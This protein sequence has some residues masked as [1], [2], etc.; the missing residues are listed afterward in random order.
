MT[1]CVFL[2]EVHQNLIETSKGRCYPS[3][4]HASFFIS[5]A[6][7]LAQEEV[8][9]LPYSLLAQSFA[10]SLLWANKTP[11]CLHPSSTPIPITNLLLTT[12]NTKSGRNKDLSHT[13]GK[14]S[15][16]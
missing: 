9:D 1:V 13:S 7:L 5:E 16:L 3:P 10:P 4:S 11:T 12:F 14:T 15:R 6:V 2:P 8:L